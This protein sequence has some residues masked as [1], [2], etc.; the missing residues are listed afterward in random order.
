MTRLLRIV[1]FLASVLVGH[2]RLAIADDTKF[3]VTG[4]WDFQTD[5]AGR[6]GTSQFVF[7][8]QGNKLAG[9]LNG[10][11]GQTGISGTVAGNKIEFQV[12]TFGGK[13]VYKGMIVDQDHMQGEANYIVSKSAWTANRGSLKPA[14]E[15]KTAASGAAERRVK[16]F[17]RLLDS[18]NIAE[19]KKYAAEN[20][21]PSFLDVPMERHL[22]FFLSMHD[23]T[24]GVEFHSIQ[25]SA[26]HQ[27]T[28]LLKNKLT[29]RWMTLQ[30]RVE[31]NPPLRIVALGG[32]G[33]PKP[34]AGAPSAK[35]RSD[36]EIRDEMQTLMEKLAD[37]DVFSGTVLL[38]RD[39]VPIFQ[40]A[41]GMANKD[42]NA[43]NR[44][45]TKFNLGSMNKMFTAVAVAQLAERGKLSFDDPLSK[46]LPDFPDRASAEKI[47]IKH[48]LTHT[49]GLGGYFSKPWQESSRA[50]YRTVDDQMK[51]AAADE[52]LLFEPGTLH[53][54][55]NTGML[56]AGKV[57][58]IASG[59]DY[60]DYVRE[61]IYTPAGMRNT[62]CYELDKVNP[63]LAVGYEKH[64]DE[65]GVSFRNNL[66]DH[67]LRDGPM[68]GGYSTV[69]D[70]LKFDIALRSNKL[71]GAESV[72]LL[73][74][75]KPELKAPRYGYGF[76]IDDE[77]KIAGHGGGFIGI[78]SNLD[79]FL[80]SPWTA[81]VMSNYGRGAMIPQQTMRELVQSDLN[82]APAVGK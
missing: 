3:D 73:L 67:V 15:P 50:L 35:K 63:N 10:Q 31:P 56:V 22:D 81:A 42:F 62:D 4:A 58:E 74:S 57:V 33:A 64:F 79:M 40:G 37:A 29:G 38:A 9:K 51:R 19:F 32:R 61:N 20:F 34:P 60:Y 7:K 1:V 68:G 59:Q 71:V 82:A 46:F 49:A 44:I 45:D 53:R 11:D 25:E 26:P 80:D 76:A 30:V 55:S 77:Q 23:M 24:R 17:A 75:S 66:F 65:G 5:V 21:A 52:R 47:K 69:E 12:P 36:D 18:G 41:Y 48:L 8:Q 78:N 28:A 70:L 39:G 6:K 16:E 54:Y 2:D 13:A 27:V 14:S 43:P 72:K